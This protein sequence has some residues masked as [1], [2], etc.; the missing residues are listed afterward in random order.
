MTD[1]NERELGWDDQITKDADEFPL[2]PEGD[3]DFVVSKFER[4]RFNG[5]DKMPACNQAIV[6]LRIHH[7]E[8]GDVEIRHSLLLHSKTEW[9]LSSFFASIGQKK[10]GEPLKMNWSLV[11]GSSGRCKIGIKTYK[12]NDYNEVK[13]FYP[14]EEKTFTPGAF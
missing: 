9:M 12:D 3:Y 8:L 4:G 14:K 6:Y 11:P 7:S 2:L 10:K 1:V 5:S 13:K